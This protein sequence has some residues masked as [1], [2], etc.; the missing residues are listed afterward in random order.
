MGTEPPNG[1]APPSYTSTAATPAD[2]FADPSSNI[3]VTASFANLSLSA[4][5]PTGIPSVDTCLAHLKFL[6][7]INSLKEDVGYTDGLWGLWDDRAEKDTGIIVDGALPSGMDLDKLNKDQKV[8]LA[9]SR[10]REKRWAIFLARAVDRYEAWW[11]A[12]SKSKQMLTESDMMTAGS[13]KYDY[14]TTSG[15][16]LPWSDDMIPPLGRYPCIVGSSTLSF[17]YMAFD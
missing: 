13:P 5:P 1:D 2:Q 4:T 10:L 7:A 3:D 11:N 8:A 17:T 9:L 15:A 14:F 6:H 16:P 12:I